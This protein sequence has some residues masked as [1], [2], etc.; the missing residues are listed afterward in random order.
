MILLSRENL[1]I[2]GNLNTEY[3]PALPSDSTNEVLRDRQ[4]DK[5]TVASSL[6]VINGKSI[7]EAY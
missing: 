2:R 3:N 4:C 1:G 5:L 6:L 7:A